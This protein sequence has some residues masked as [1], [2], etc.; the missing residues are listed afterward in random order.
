MNINGQNENM[1][2][3]HT[4]WSEAWRYFRTYAEQAPL[5]EAAWSRAVDML[6]EIAR[7]HPE[8]EDFAIAAAL[9]AF[10]WLEMHDKAER[11]KKNAA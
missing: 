6:P 7:R 1:K 2:S 10:K 11:K 4:I 3:Y 9:T 5:S 8:H